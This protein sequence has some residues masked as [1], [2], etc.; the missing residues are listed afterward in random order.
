MISDANPE[1]GPLDND[2]NGSNGDQNNRDL[3]Q[4]RDE[5]DTEISPSL[6][7]AGEASKSSASG[8]DVNKL[9][10]DFSSGVRFSPRVKK[11]MEQARAELRALA[12]AFSGASSTGAES[13]TLDAIPPPAA[14][15]EA[16]AASTAMLPPADVAAV[17][18][19]AA[20]ASIRASSALP[21]LA[22]VAAAARTP[23][24]AIFPAAA[25]TIAPACARPPRLAVVAAAARTPPPADFPAVAEATVATANAPDT[26][27]NTFC[28][29][30]D[31]AGEFLSREE[32]TPHLVYAEEKTDKLSPS[33]GNY[34]RRG[35][36]KSATKATPLKD[37]TQQTDAGSRVAVS[38]FKPSMPASTTRKQIKEVI[39]FGGI[40]QK[41]S[42]PVRLSE[43]VKMEKNRDATQMERA[44]MMTEQRLYAISPG[45]KSK[46]SFSALSNSEIG[47]RANKLGI[48]LGAN[49]SKI[50]TSISSLKQC[51]EDRR[52]TYLQ[53]NLNS[54]IDGNSD[55]NILATANSLC[56][57][58][59]LEDQIEP[60]DNSSDPS[61]FMPTKC[62]KKQKKKTDTKLGV[63][64]R[65][66][67]RINKSLKIKK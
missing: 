17:T 43:R 61:L 33:Q 9:A 59:A 42:S 52:I 64:V 10:S 26:A 23:P 50:N 5:M 58:L 12:D 38:S 32:K 46:L 48:S 41:L 20:S 22:D 4:G 53:N 11:M 47:A 56:S 37:Q 63:A 30:Q 39:T 45:T 16:E 6:E 31:S 1:D 24:S 66:S 62:L 13:P 14:A 18:E 55:S 65:R 40:S 49:E 54:C 19:T 34:G 67:S 60:I 15:A 35:V 25:E 44:M 2:G 3:K 27:T 8:P 29:P 7:S 51:E 21:R 57:D 36:E 28:V